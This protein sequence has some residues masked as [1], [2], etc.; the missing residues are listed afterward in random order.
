MNLFFLFSLLMLTILVS[1]YDFRH[2]RIPNWV[3]MPLF[4]TGF[5]LNSPHPFAL[6]ILLLSFWITWKLG[7]MGAGD[8]KLWMGL[9]VSVPPAYQLLWAIPFIFFVTGALQ[10]T[11]RKIKGKALFG[12]RSP[13][14]WRTSLY[15]LVI[16]TQELPHAH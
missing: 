7:W 6:Y 15:L 2:T 8:A 9:V 1:I 3:T 5:M 4:I 11:Q 16:L 10:I 14:A 13:G 12:V